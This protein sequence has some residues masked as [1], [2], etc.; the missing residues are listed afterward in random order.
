MESRTL[1]STGHL[2]SSRSARGGAATESPLI[3]YDTVQ[4]LPLPTR[5]STRWRQSVTKVVQ[6]IQ[7][8]LQRFKAQQAGQHLCMGF[9]VLKWDDFQEALPQPRRGVLLK[10]NFVDNLNNS[11]CND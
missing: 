4:P 9:L 2:N 1:S 6:D 8:L 10:D 11:L 5:T 7:S 3:E